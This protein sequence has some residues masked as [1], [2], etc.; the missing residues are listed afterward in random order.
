[1]K[2]LTGTRRKR[3]AR[4]RRP[5]ARDRDT[6]QRVLDAAHRVLIRRGTA[7]ARM[8]E[9]AA[10]AGVNQALLHYYFRNKDRLSKAVFRSAAAEL[11]PR[12]VEVLASGMP[13]E[14]KVRQVVRV[15]LDQL[16][17]T[18]YLPGYILSEVHHHP[19]RIIQLVGDVTGLTPGDLRPRIIAGVQAQIDAAVHAGAVRPIAA[20]QFL[21]N[22]LSL[23]I[24]PF[25][26]RP[27]IMAIAG[28][29]ER[30]FAH[31]IDQ[32]RDELAD[33]FL[34]AVRP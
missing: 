21:I 17:R 32:R 10:E 14:D 25:A 31:F 33:F 24:F 22:L 2:R 6:E 28:L 7:G 20:E 34:R 3:P 18:P 27:M 12:V 5:A 11:L 19:E 4:R 1:M 30:G 23:C 9:I 16:S 8:Q 13:L 29:D 15:E 26:A